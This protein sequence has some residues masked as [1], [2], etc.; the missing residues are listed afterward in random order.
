ML[1]DIPAENNIQEALNNGQVL[2]IIRKFSKPS[3][4]LKTNPI[5]TLKCKVSQLAKVIWQKLHQI[6]GGRSITM[7]LR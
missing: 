7:F 6:R 2:Y 5:Y 1:K 3:S 4:T